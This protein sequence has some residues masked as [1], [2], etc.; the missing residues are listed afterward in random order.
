[1]KKKSGYAI[2]EGQAWQDRGAGSERDGNKHKKLLYLM[3]S[4]ASLFGEPL[5][6]PVEVFFHH[7]II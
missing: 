2:F 7:I 4:S 6:D 3:Y 1:M 5:M